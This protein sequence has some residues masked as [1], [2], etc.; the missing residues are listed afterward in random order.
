MPV[1]AVTSQI[2][3]HRTM[4]IERPM[5]PPREFETVENYQITDTFCEALARI[6]RVGPCHR[7]V[8]YVTERIDHQRSVRSVVSRLILP[9]PSLVSLAQM[10]AIE[11][12]EVNCAIASHAHSTFAH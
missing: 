11:A 2:W 6:D 9:A 1:R 12:G 7:L 4:T 8:F 10:V 3:K 5:F